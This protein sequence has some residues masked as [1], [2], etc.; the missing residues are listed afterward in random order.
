MCQI[1]DINSW[2]V[3]VPRAGK[4]D[5]TR[6]SAGS[7]GGLLIKPDIWRRRKETVGD[8]ADDPGLVSDTPGPGCKGGWGWG[9]RWGFSSVQSAFHGFLRKRAFRFI[10]AVIGFLSWLRWGF[11]RSVK[12]IRQRPKAL[13]KLRHCSPKQQAFGDQ[14]RR[15]GHDA[16]SPSREHVGSEWRDTA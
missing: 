15:S 9:W 16:M 2:R 11:A 14:D 13:A 7:H 4:P 1:V 10:V 5:G 3:A 8:G 6:Q 12:G